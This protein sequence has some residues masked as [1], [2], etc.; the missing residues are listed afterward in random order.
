MYVPK[1]SRLIILQSTLR[2]AKSINNE[3]VRKPLVVEDYNATK[4]AID[5]L[6]WMTVACYS[7]KRESKRLLSR[8][9]YNVYVLFAVIERNWNR[10][11]L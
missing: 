2:R 9:A 11:I 1:K 3:E 6:D 8:I 7:T 5:V 10:N 4:N